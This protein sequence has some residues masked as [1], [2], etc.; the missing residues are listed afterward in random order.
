MENTVKF[1]VSPNPGVEWGFFIPKQR[2]PTNRNTSSI[3]L[4]PATLISPP[5]DP[6]QR[7]LEKPPAKSK[8]LVTKPI[9]LP[10]MLQKIEA[11]LKGPPST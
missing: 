5:C 1:P 7:P 3:P 2:P 4:S 9:E 8:F 11:F 6:T 10:R